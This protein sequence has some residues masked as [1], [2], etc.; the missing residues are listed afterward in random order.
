[1][2]DLRTDSLLVRNRFLFV[3]LAGF[4]MVPGC[5]ATSWLVSLALP[6]NSTLGHL[7]AHAIVTGLFLILMYVLGVAIWK[8]FRSPLAAAFLAEKMGLE[9]LNQ[10]D[11]TVAT[12]FGGEV[13][14]HR[15]A[16]ITY[17]GY[18]RYHLEGESRVRF[19]AYLRIVL[20]LNI[21]QPLGVNVQR[22]PGTRRTAESFEQAFP[23]QKNADRLSPRAQ[24]AMLDFITRDRHTKH[25]SL[26]SS[27][28]DIRSL[29][30]RDRAGAPETLIGTEIFPDADVILVHDR[31]DAIDVTPDQLQTKLG[32]M[33]EVAT[34]IQ[35]P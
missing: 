3:L 34:A 16:I 25:R 18:S 2:R 29:T 7:L 32:E 33:I 19:F 1:M 12:W 15:F 28:P 5:C 21:T 8:S 20:A 13:Q 4:L 14:G 30:L 17:R 24:Q 35:N 10:A 23:V 6:K 9:P 27:A 26:F 22:N 11:R 31:P